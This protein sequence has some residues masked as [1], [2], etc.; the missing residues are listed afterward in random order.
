[1]GRELTRQ[2]LL[3]LALV[4]VVCALAAWPAWLWGGDEGLLALGVA[5]LICLLAGALAR[6]ATAALQG[7]STDESA[8]PQAVQAGIGVRLL[9]TLGASLPVILTHWVPQ[10]QFVAWLGLH[11]L[12][13]MAL[14]L[15]VSMRELGQNHGPIDATQSEP[16][17]SDAKDGVAE[18]RDANDA[19][20]KDAEENGIQGA[21]PE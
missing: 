15:F 21:K 16:E 2:L 17:D 14:E 20:A 10:R 6:V 18:D 19:V 12:S 7:L 1:M 8:A 4:V 13:Q 9:L 5:G 3:V 11:Y